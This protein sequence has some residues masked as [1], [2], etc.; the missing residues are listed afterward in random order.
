MRSKYLTAVAVALAC[1]AA[2]DAEARRRPQPVAAEPVQASSSEWPH[3][4]FTPA[5]KPDAGGRRATA[6]SRPESRNRLSAFDGQRHSVGPR[7]GAWCGW[8]M[9]TRHGGG[10]EMNVAWN[11]RHYGSPGSP[12]IGAIVVWRHHVGEIVGQTSSGKWIIL[13]GND[14]HRVRERARSIAGAIVRI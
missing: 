13:S 1:L 8:Y 3:S 7:P 12:Q 6:R 10:S 2:S 4:A 5:S 14:S 11:W 9:R